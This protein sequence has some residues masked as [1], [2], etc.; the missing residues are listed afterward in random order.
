M[1]EAFDRLLDRVKERSSTYARCV[2]STWRPWPTRSPRP[3]RA[4]CVEE[5]RPAYGVAAEIAARVQHACF[6]DVDAPVTR[7]G[8]VEV[9]MPYAKNLESAALPNEDKILAA[10]L[11]TLG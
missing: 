10:A 2:R 3:T 5:G 1:V 11:A 6:D 7:I 9:P 8:T 4:L